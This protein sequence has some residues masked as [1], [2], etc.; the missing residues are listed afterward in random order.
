MIVPHL[1]RVRM[2]TVEMK[3]EIRRPVEVSQKVGPAR[4]RNLPG[5]DEQNRQAALGQVSQPPERA[6]IELGCVVVRNVLIEESRADA[7][8]DDRP[9][10][11]I[12][13]Q[14]ADQLVELV[15]GESARHKNPAE[16]GFPAVAELR[17]QARN[18]VRIKAIVPA[19]IDHLILAAGGLRGITQAERIGGGAVKSD[20]ACRSEQ[21]SHRK[22][23]AAEWQ[24]SHCAPPDVEGETAGL[25]AI[26]GPIFG[27]RLFE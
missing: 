19:D 2:L 13:I 23:R 7:G 20:S 14:P 15:G 4:A 3:D 8:D 10:H 1:Q 6:V 18:R 21:R 27:Q 17:S 24:S 9:G 16:R 26:I 12:R 5:L 22:R 25:I 11:L